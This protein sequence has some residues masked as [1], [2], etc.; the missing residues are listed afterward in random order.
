MIR[1][2][3]FVDWVDPTGH[4]A[5]LIEEERPA[6]CLLEEPLL[7]GVRP[8]ECPANVAEQLALQQALGNRRAVD[9]DERIRR[10]R[11]VVVEGSRH[12]F[13]A[14]SA[15]AGDENTGAAVGDLPDQGEDFAHGRTR[16]DQVTE[17][18]GLVHR[19]PQAPVL[20]LQGAP[21]DRAIDG[22]HH[23]LG[24]EGLG[25]IVEGTRPHRLDDRIDASE[26]RHQHHRGIRA[27][28]PDLTD[29]LDPRPAGHLDVAQDDVVFDVPKALQRLVGGARLLDGEATLRE[30]GDEHLPHR[31]IVIDDK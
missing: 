5:D 9:R 3:I 22:D 28:L 7:R 11:S 15:L 27:H 1:T 29:H 18:A 14:G 19:T 31:E 4:I 23:R 21:L 13:L 8:G 10:A 20:L 6:H 24:L 12:H 16:A 30:E 17:G 26:G 2:S 25:D